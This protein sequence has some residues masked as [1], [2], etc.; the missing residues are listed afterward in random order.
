MSDINHQDRLMRTYEVC[1]TSPD[2]PTAVELVNLSYE[3]ND[4][5]EPVNRGG[6]VVE[7]QSITARIEVMRRLRKLAERAATLVPTDLIENA[8]WDIRLVR[9]AFVKVPVDE[10]GAPIPHAH[11]KENIND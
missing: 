8:D 6:T 7:A 9:T 2:F 5:L 10:S 3:L 1:L 11:V 4:G